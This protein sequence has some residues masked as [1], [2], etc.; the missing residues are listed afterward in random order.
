MVSSLRSQSFRELSVIGIE[1]S[2]LSCGR[3]Y[4]NI[5][6]IKMLA[7]NSP[8]ENSTPFTAPAREQ[9]ISVRISH[10]TERNY[11]ASCNFY[12][13]LLGHWCGV[14]QQRSDGREPKGQDKPICH[15]DIIFSHT[16]ITHTY[17]LSTYSWQRKEPISAVE[18]GMLLN[19][20]GQVQGVD[21]R[22]KGSNEHF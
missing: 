21:M 13:Q 9:L 17:S 20:Q 14:L 16:Y 18:E 4:Y 3:E 8:W 22:N 2:S 7:F 11:L 1:K 6:D 5:L 19:F 15:M 12:W 10:D